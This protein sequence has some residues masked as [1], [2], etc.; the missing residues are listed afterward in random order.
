MAKDRHRERRETQKVGNTV[1]IAVPAID[2]IYE[3][4]PK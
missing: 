2:A 4:T 3:K 1:N